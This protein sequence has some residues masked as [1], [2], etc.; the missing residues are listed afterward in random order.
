MKTPNKNSELFDEPVDYIY[1][2]ALFDEITIRCI[3]ISVLKALYY[4]TL[5]KTNMIKGRI[6]T[7][8]M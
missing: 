3:I 6:N 5:I 2:I 4:R 8:I 1:M 7:V